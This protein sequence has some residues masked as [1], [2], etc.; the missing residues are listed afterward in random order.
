MQPFGAVE[1]IK[2]SYQRYVE[3]SFPLIDTALR[4]EFRRLIRDEHL[5]WQEPYVSLSRP[6]LSGGTLGDLVSE[7]VVGPELLEGV[8]GMH[9][10]DLKFP[11]LYKH[12][13]LAVERLTTFHK[14]PRNTLIA[15]GTGSGKTE[16][17]L[18]P[19]I[20][21]CLRHRD[22]KGIQAVIVY[23]MNALANDQLSRLQ[24]VLRGTGVT[25]ARYTGET[26]QSS[27]SR[28]DKSPP[29]ERCTRTEIY[30]DPP[31]ILLTNYSMLEYLLVRKR[32]RQ[33]FL[34]T[35]P[36]YL[37][38]DEIHTYIGILGSEVAC[39]I[40]RFK[41]HARLEP[42]QL[43]CVGTSATLM[44]P[45]T[46]DETG[47][48]KKAHSYTELL[49]FA[50]SLFGEAF[51]PWQESIIGEHYQEM[52]QVSEPIPL[53]ENPNLDAMFFNDF[54]S[55]KEKDVRTLA[56]QFHLYL[57][58]GITGEAFFTN[59]YE[60]LLKQPVFAKFEELLKVPKSLDTLVEWLQKRPER[61]GV[62]IE[63]LKREA[64][65]ILLLGSIAYRIDPSNP[66]DEE[67]L[68]RPKVHLCMR[69]LTPIT[70]T[71][72]LK[73]GVGTLLSEGKTEEKQSATVETDKQ[74][75]TP[76]Y[77]LPLA[78]CRSCGTHYLKG[79]YEQDEEQFLAMRNATAHSSRTTR[80]KTTKKSKANE[81]ENQQLPDMLLL[82][83]NQPH[84]KIYQEIYVHLLPLDEKEKKKEV[85][86]DR[87]SG[88]VAEGE[89]TELAQGVKV[90]REYRVCPYCL[91]AQATD[92][93]A[94]AFEHGI[95]NCEGKHIELPTFFGFTRA[96]R[97]PVCKAQGHGSRDIITL[98][99]SGAAATVSILTE[100]LLSQLKSDP[101]HGIDE[102][103]ML[104]FAD[105]R[106][107]TAHQAGYIRDRHQTFTQRQ[108]TYKTVE[109]Y[110]DSTNLCLPLENLTQEVYKF[111]K[112]EWKSEADALN[113][114]ALTYSAKSPS[115][116]L[117]QSTELISKNERERAK[118]RLEWDLYM[119]FTDRSNSRNSLE[120][121]GLIA[122]QYAD[123]EDV[124]LEN[125]GQ[126]A[127]FGFTAKRED[128]HFLE[129]LL[130]V[131]MDY[132]RRQKAVDYAP[133]KD[134]LSGGSDSVAEGTA[135]PTKYTRTPN[136]FDT[137]G[138]QS[139]GAYKV[140][141][142]YNA[143]AP[144]SR[145][146][147]IFDA[148]SRMLEGY[149]VKDITDCIDAAVT[150]LKKK[151][152]IREVKIGQQ[153]GG[154]ANKKR[155]AYQLNPT[156]LEA[157][158]HSEHFRC[159]S[160]GD[161]RSYPIHRWKT[162]LDPNAK[163]IC[164]NYKCKGTTRQDFYEDRKRNFY[165]QFYQN[166]KPERLYAVEHS[167]QLSG[168]ERE[169]I[170]IGF[171]EGR[172]N[173]LVCT[174]TLELG[175][176]IGDLLAI[177]LRNMPP[178]P[179]NYS[180][181]SG[182]AGRK[183]KIALILSHAGQGP[184]DT[185]FFKRLD[186]MI[187]GQIRP[188]VF[189]IDNKVVIRRHLN[190]L[191]MEKLNI[192]LPSRWQDKAGTRDVD[193]EDNGDE[194]DAVGGSLVDQQGE[195]HREWLENLENEFRQQI[196]RNRETIVSSVKHAFVQERKTEN[197]KLRW[198]D[199]AFVEERCDLFAREMREGL[200]HWCQRYEEIY[201]ELVRMNRKVLLSKTEERRR[202]TL[203]TALRN[204]L[205]N[206]E[207]RPLNYLARVGFLPRYGF[208]GKVVTVHDDEERQIVQVAS[209]GVTEYALGNIV[210]VAGKK[211]QINR[212]HFRGG[213][214][215]NPLN[216][217]VPYKYCLTC[218]YMTEQPTA[219]E[220]PYCHQFLVSRQEVEYE[221]AHGWGNE[222]ISQEDE[223]R[224][225]QAY[226]LDTYLTALPEK[227]ELEN[228][229]IPVPEEK[230]LGGFEVK[231][232]RLRDITLFNRGKYD[233]TTGD[234]VP[235]TV[236]LEC[237]A[238]IR[239]RTLD[240]DEAERAGFRASGTDHLYSCSVRT[241][242]D[243]RYV[244]AVDLKVQLQGDVVEIALPQEETGRKDFESWVTTLQ[245]AFKLGLQLELFIKP[246]EIQSYVANYKINGRDHKKLV[247]YDTMPG[248]TGYLKRFYDNL[249]QIAARVLDHLR[250]E[251]C[252]TACYSCLKEFWNQ[253]FHSLLDKRLIYN[254]LEQLAAEK[255]EVAL[256]A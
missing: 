126:F 23:P 238:W 67:P 144:T 220:C 226:N 108:L 218:N 64:A 74:A 165:V 44:S 140:Y 9:A 168:E 17:F 2:E 173:A 4:E 34:H 143:D 55:T 237:G 57:K 60:A 65:G 151:T 127:R 185:Y 16:S 246:G 166:S 58:Q 221:M 200:E 245:E 187:A 135:R 99:R 14:D 111:S 183:R 86:E 121:E 13:R 222:T 76:P 247:L 116:G 105:S 51:D 134:Y 164:A 172:I 153:S 232:S 201:Q 53:W 182:R 109:Q 91:R 231:Y 130:R 141:G 40:R 184:H 107:D 32:D 59:L 207:Y 36:R 110:E 10:P 255:S 240:H 244:Q 253:R 118:K 115:A 8:D 5:L 227:S 188:P 75:K 243:S 129:S 139:P 125:I 212:I 97:C 43:C 146:T 150:L 12:Q 38:L 156:Y 149:P 154:T 241:D 104:I 163:T 69:S 224:D 198:L 160:C 24:K 159:S 27:E 101:E 215:E 137:K 80:R 196:N 106:Q 248:G 204:L 210:Y 82:T 85:I 94:E 56:A 113:L 158:I 219:Q 132:M 235:F 249:P 242:I 15:T 41:E 157:T 194:I 92:I 19:I 228:S 223:Y 42:Q 35:K 193:D 20:D 25:F 209:V 142:W 78:V 133:F 63:Y 18:I 161:V 79:Y 239:P 128:I 199:D 213:S 98:M 114:L 87:E 189:L 120:R 155:N 190:S 123:L 88:D 170:E 124:A 147:A 50:A 96:T 28:D 225:L 216:N 30:A 52:P 230:A 203:L 175:V 77:A 217:A 171:K 174:Q 236:C 234:L 181:R 229:A 54:D 21:H 49:A 33:I 167:G 39:L 136:G 81:K 192:S 191:I 102:K 138:D 3:T 195:L 186:E 254:V 233:S 7:H 83:P 100:S 180:Q 84:S 70:M 90:S 26:K 211:L 117:K 66:E 122:I 251:E 178:T 145:I 72:N 37:V 197:I 112:N 1:K 256:L 119:E 214:K 47:S 202:N 205:E 177:I 45:P 46:S 250:K 252:E 95:E 68:Y 131:I 206:R 179:S 48:A 29:E 11:R 148:V 162:H 208:P 93:A 62:V 152:Y 169:K 71:L 103:K 6:F 89:D 176:D 61:E 73:D 22:E 31:Q